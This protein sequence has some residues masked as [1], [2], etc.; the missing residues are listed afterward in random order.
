M[1]ST[2]CTCDDSDAWGD[3]RLSGNY[4]GLIDPCLAALGRL[5]LQIWLLA[6]LPNVATQFSSA[7]LIKNDRKIGGGVR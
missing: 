3:P 1:H 6:S 5:G 7:F 2:V 4:L